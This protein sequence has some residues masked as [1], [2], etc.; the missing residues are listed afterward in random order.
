[1]GSK[2][3]Y[4][5]VP[6]SY[7]QIAEYEKWLSDLAQEGLILQ[8]VGF[9]WAK[10]KK[11]KPQHLTYRIDIS[12]T[13]LSSQLKEQ[14]GWKAI[15]TATRYSVYVSSQTEQD[16]ELIENMKETMTQLKSRNLG[17]KV[18]FGVV[19]A[20]ILFTIFILKMDL[21]D[22][23]TPLLSFLRNSGINTIGIL[24]IGQLI[25]GSIVFVE[26]RGVKRLIKSL[27]TK[28]CIDRQNIHRGIGDRLLNKMRF[29]G[30]IGFLI[31]AGYMVGYGER[32][33]LNG[34]NEPIPIVRL[35]AMEERCAELDEYNYYE[36]NWNPLLRDYYEVEEEG[37]I[38]E[39][40]VME[41]RPYIYTEFYHLLFEGMKERLIQ[42]IKQ[43]RG[44][45]GIGTEQVEG[46]D[47]LH[48]LKDSGAIELIAVK[49]SKVMFVR[50]AGNQEKE[51]LIEEIT[52]VM[53]N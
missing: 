12:N 45:G 5:R 8:K 41:K 53:E 34:V 51:K 44:N 52:K 35:G 31:L 20:L 28:G 4:K 6:F 33:N 17:N 10:F 48:V 1:M 16:V 18:Y 30:S 49:G 22:S 23:N 9:L 29:I 14:Y 7:W 21:L 3:I 37:I 38:A 32:T 47:E 19:G 42:E 46:L 40:N 26:Y 2:F 25:I 36:R 24:I 27:E 50:Y 15:E 13:K 11:G 39:S 43:D